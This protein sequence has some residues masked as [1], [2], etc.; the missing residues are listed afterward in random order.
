MSKEYE[1]FY[2]HDINSLMLASHLG[3]DGVVQLFLQ[4]G[5]M[6]NTLNSTKRTALSWAA[7]AGNEAVVQLL[8]D[9]YANADKNSSDIR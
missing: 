9:R 4:D 8:L 3:L 5:L 7:E 6:V 1:S 2:P